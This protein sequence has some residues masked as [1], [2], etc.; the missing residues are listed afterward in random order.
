MKFA[1]QPIRKSRGGWSYTQVI[2]GFVAAAVGVWL[3]AYYLNVRVEDLAYTALDESQLLKKL[4][5]RWRPEPPPTLVRDAEVDAEQLADELRQDLKGLEQEV[6]TLLAEATSTTADAAGTGVGDAVRKAIDARSRTYWTRLQE[7]S[8]E[9]A[10]LGSASEH[11]ID[12]KN[13]SRTLQVR[14]RVYRYGAKAINAL[15]TTEVDPQALELAESLRGWYEHGAEL[16]EKTL[17]VWQGA[18][19]SGL[20]GPTDLTPIQQQFEQES[21][22]LRTKSVDVRQ[23]LVRRYGTEFPPIE[24]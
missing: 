17:A 3:G 14:V 23:Q 2:A 4:P 20:G 8:T 9:V 19:P 11:A 15:D 22:L 21:S 1:F 10:R 18:Q 6:A 16:N 7:I 5:D 12:E 24:L 13:A